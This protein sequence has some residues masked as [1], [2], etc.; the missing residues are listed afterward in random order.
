MALNTTCMLSTVKNTS[1]SAMKFAFL[2]P[3]GRSMAISEE[4]T[5]YGDIRESITRGTPGMSPRVTNA[6]L[7]ALDD[8]TLDII[9]TPSPIFYD[10]MD[11]ASKQLTIANNKLFSL[12]TC[13]VGSES[14]AM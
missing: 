4:L 3:H 7:D 2:P 13:W 8:G 11:D 10:A 5:F 9:S 6:M 14:T 12:D 1:G